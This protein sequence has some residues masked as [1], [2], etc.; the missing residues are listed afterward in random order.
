M[1]VGY[2]GQY[3]GTTFKEMRT[4]QWDTHLSPP[5]I[6][7]GSNGRPYAANNQGMVAG[8]LSGTPIRGN[9]Q[10]V[11]WESA[12]A[13]AIHL[14]D[15][16]TNPG[17]FANGYAYSINASGT[18]V[19]EVVRYDSEGNNVGRSA[20][21]W[22]VG[23]APIELTVAQPDLAVTMAAVEIGDDGTIAGIARRPDI[24][25]QFPQFAVVRWGPGESI[26]TV[27]GI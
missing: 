12:G 4:V 19:G 13:Q 24:P 25:N 8:I 18:V 3:D 17:G 11:R 9:A 14:D 26:G 5:V 6:Y 2:V 21:R 15:L 20:V 16:G 27:L 22:D 1:I 23:Q 10:P 7:L